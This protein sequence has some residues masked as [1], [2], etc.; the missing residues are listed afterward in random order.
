MEMKSAAKV[1]I[2]AIVG[3][4]L[5]FFGWKFLAHT[6]S[7]AITL[8]AD[9]SNI[10]G[11][12]KQTPLQMNGV[13]V[14]EVKDVGFAK[15]TLKPRVTLAIDDK[16][17]DR[18]PVDSKIRITSGILI[19][20]AKIEIIPGVN[21]QTYEDGDTWRNVDDSSGDML[22]SVSPEADQLIKQLNTTIKSIAPK[23]DATMTHFE[24]ILKRTES[25]MTNVES[26]T[27]SAKNLI[28]NPKI[29]QT[30]V[31]TLDDLQGLAKEARM[32]AKSMSVDLKATFKRNSEKLDLLTG[33]A[34]DLLQKFADTVD[35]TRLA[36]T[37]LTEQATD[38]RVE[39][40]TESISFD[41]RLYAVDIRG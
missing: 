40:F 14:G 35:A 18:I 28:A 38:P 1:G 34:V 21:Y 27:V 31:S 24:G 41:K 12:A 6:T 16:F 17:R 26:M 7:K 22:S 9:F 2:F 36:V 39:V 37:K 30:M 11:L 25:A 10:K 33:G 4:V 29:Q 23:L 20:S 3:F 15:G 8:Y 32:T 13:T 19:T 5:F